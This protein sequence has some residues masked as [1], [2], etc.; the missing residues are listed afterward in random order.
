MILALHH[1][2]MP[3]VSNSHAYSSLA[4]S[5]NSEFLV[6]D[7]QSSPFDLIV[8]IDSKDSKFFNNFFNH[9]LSYINQNYSSDAIAK[10][11][12]NLIK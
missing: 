11:L 4:K 12:L 9:S 3:I 5:L 8:K 7:N 6:F 2:V 1:L 10:K